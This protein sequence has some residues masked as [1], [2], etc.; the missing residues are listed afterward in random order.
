MSCIESVWDRDVVG[1]S[2]QSTG[3]HWYIRWHFSALMCAAHDMHRLDL[4]YC[5][6]AA[7][8][9]VVQCAMGVCQVLLPCALLERCAARPAFSQRR[10]VLSA[11]H[12]TFHAVQEG[13][14][15]AGALGWEGHAQELGAALP[16]LVEDSSALAAAIKQVKSTAAGCMRCKHCHCQSL[17]H[18]CSCHYT[19]PLL[20][21]QSCPSG[22]LTPEHSFNRKFCASVACL[23]CIERAHCPWCSTKPRLP[24][25]HW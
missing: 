3:R 10:P 21:V 19:N 22:Q 9:P 4:G 17:D 25:Q 12:K 2:T 14:A 20:R 24:Q 6:W 15:A 1:R 23:L 8:T 16:K 18:Q 11:S 5:L 13:C 7:S